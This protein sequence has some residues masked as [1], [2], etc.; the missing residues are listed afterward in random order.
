MAFSAV[1]AAGWGSRCAGVCWEL[2]LVIFGHLES[3]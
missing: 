1:G 3:G 2:Y